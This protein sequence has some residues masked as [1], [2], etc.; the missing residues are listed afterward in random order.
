MNAES[1][2]RKVPEDTACLIDRQRTDTWMISL[3]MHL[4][5]LQT[6]AS[7]LTSTKLGPNFSQAASQA[8]TWPISRDAPS[9]KDIAEKL[10]F[11]S[12][13]E[14][15]L[16]RHDRDCDGLY[17]VLPL[18]PGLPVLLAEH[19]DRNPDKQPLKGR[20]G[21]VHSWQL[22]ER[23]SS[24]S[25][26]EARL[27]RYQPKVVVVKFCEMRE[28]GKIFAEKPYTWQLDGITG[29]GIYPIQPKT[30]GWYLDQRREKP[31]LLVRRYQLPLA[32]AFAIT[33][34]AIVKAKLC[35][36]PF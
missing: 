19:Y 34:H 4:Q 28:E 2:S 24:V 12:G 32:P 31:Q 9:N 15:W 1:A 27:L 30:R 7:S 25:E 14:V 16:T 23:E 20:T 3:S 26:G 13:K 22:Y 6:T 21:Y 29:P 18:V 11:E 33:A 8:V 36:Q 5:V 17:D 10:N 35:E